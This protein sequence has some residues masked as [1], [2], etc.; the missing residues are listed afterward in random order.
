MKLIHFLALLPFVGMLVLLPLV[1]KVQP[2]ILGMPFILFW[3]V[4]WAV[5]SSACLVLIYK[6]DPANATEGGEE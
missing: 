3:V 1:N 5:L 4:L 2:F 6:L